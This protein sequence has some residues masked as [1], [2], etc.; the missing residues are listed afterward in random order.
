MYYQKAEYV[1]WGHRPFLSSSCRQS[2]SGEAAVSA[3]GAGLPGVA[4]PLCTASLSSAW[5]HTAQAA[6]VTCSCLFSC[7]YC[8][9]EAEQPSRPDA[10]LRNKAGMHKSCVNLPVFAQPGRD[11]Q[12][13]HS[14]HILLCWSK[15]FASR[16]MAA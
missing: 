2:P 10:G 11:R 9:G 8:A 6:S 7:A 5:G 13:T 1:M 3:G 16:A 15:K 14:S 4:V 12:G